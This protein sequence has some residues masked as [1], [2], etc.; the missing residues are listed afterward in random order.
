MNKVVYIL[1]AVSGSGKSTLAKELA[2]Q[3]S[4][5]EICEADLYF[6]KN[7]KYEFDASQ[8]GAAHAWCHS[9]FTRALDNPDVDCII[10]SNTNT[11][12]RDFAFYEKE[13]GKRGILTFVLVVENR[14][15][16]IDVHGVPDEVKKNQAKNLSESI[17]LI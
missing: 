13:A 17:R 14:H 5:A 15:G 7:G 9:C 12:P 16:G 2:N 1:R 8:L 4:H 11:K 10:V 6:M 3:Y